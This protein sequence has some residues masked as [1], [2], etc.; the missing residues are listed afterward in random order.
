MT[1]LAGWVDEALEVNRKG[2][3]GL[4]GLILAIDGAPDAA[5][6]TERP[7][8]CLPLVLHSQ[9]LLPCF[10]DALLH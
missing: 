9:H 4:K 8:C 7:L 5:I 10:E 1:Y 6:F 2:G 3:G